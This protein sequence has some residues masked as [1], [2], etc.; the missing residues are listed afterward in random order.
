MAGLEAAGGA[1]RRDYNAGHTDTH[2]HAYTRMHMHTHLHVQGH[3]RYL[4][5]GQHV[6]AVPPAPKCPWRHCRPRSTQGRR[7]RKT[8]AGCIPRSHRSG[9]GRGR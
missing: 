7:W 5:A 2:T 8:T 6:R 1:V 3:A 4:G 9:C